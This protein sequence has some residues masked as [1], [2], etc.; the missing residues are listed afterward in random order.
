M[1]RVP[2][3]PHVHEDVNDS[4]MDE[5]RGDRAPRFPTKGVL[6]SVRAPLEELL[7]CPEPWAKRRSSHG[8]ENGY[9][10]GDDRHVTEG[11][12][13][14]RNELRDVASG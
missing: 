5:D 13:R 4:E 10:D 9:V 3:A 7:R 14:S 2:E 11:P 8:K 12:T 6:A 1:R